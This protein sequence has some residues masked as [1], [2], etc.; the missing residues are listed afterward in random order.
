MKTNSVD[1]TLARLCG[2]NDKKIRYFG[3]GRFG[4]PILITPMYKRK[5]LVQNFRH[6]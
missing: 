1:L 4:V 5:Y 6:N 2:L 3:S